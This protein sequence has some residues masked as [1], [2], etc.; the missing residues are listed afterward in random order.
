MMNDAA[1]LTD[2]SD[3]LCMLYAVW[4]L[5]VR[6]TRPR[7]ACKRLLDSRARADFGQ[8]LRRCFFKVSD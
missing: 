2:N 3:R 5:I 1:P 4:K 6:S 8:R 7:W